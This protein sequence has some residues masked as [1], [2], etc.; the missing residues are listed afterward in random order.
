M[1]SQSFISNIKG[2]PSFN[3]LRPGYHFKIK[4]NEKQK[5]VIQT[6]N[7][8]DFI[9]EFSIVTWK[10]SNCTKSNI[11]ICFMLHNDSVNCTECTHF[12][13]SESEHKIPANG[14]FWPDNQ[15]INK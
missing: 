13:P 5:I 14:T 4:E 8:F 9:V 2:F 15:S 1:F 3:H 6:Q 11:Y 7:V 10:P 12:S